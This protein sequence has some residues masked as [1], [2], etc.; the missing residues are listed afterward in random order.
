MII[1]VDFDGTI[2]EHKFPE[3]GEEF[4]K[5]ID[6]L[7]KW[8][9]AG[10]KIII[11]TCREKPYIQPMLDWLKERGFIPDAVNENIDKNL[12]YGQHKVYA[13]LYIDDRAQLPDWN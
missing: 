13:D 7:K 3:I 8:Q 1:A 9:I 12:T 6:W 2:C 5:A 4:P 11:W 10:H